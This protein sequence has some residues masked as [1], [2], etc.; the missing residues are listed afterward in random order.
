MDSYGVI[1]I[2]DHLLSIPGL[3]LYLALVAGWCYFV[4]KLV[5]GIPK[6]YRWLNLISYWL[7]VAAIIGWV[8]IALGISFYVEA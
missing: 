2:G 3:V 8:F 5:T 6:R 4:S 1:T 7:S